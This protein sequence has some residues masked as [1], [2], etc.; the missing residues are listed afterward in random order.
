MF[1]LILYISCDGKTTDTADPL[2]IQ[3]TSDSTP[4]IEWDVAKENAPE[5]LFMS[6]WAFSDDDIWIVGGQVDSG[7]V[8]RGA[9]DQWEPLELPQDTP[10]LNW[11]NGT[12]NTDIWVGG[13]QGTLL[14]WNG[15]AWEDHSLDIEEAIWGI[16]AVSATDVIAVGGESKW[17]GSVAT[18]AH[19]DGS[20]WANID[21]PDELSDASNLFKVS[22]DGSQY[23]IVGA[24][25]ALI[26]G[27]GESFEA[28]P[29][30][31]TTD[32][33]TVH[34]NGERTQIV[35]GRGTGL[36]IDIDL[37][38]NL[39]S[40]VQAITGLNGV[41]IIDDSQSFVVGERGYGAFYSNGQFEEIEAITVDVLHATFSSPNGTIYAVGGNLFTSDPTFHGILLYITP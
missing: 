11:V 27:D 24:E 12:S 20:E 21:L 8:L 1:L 18:I 6:A 13:L 36:V 41:H 37:N 19:Y 10:L 30:G 23:W 34:H 26:T 31:I 29:S 16:Y 15:S 7:L 5:G 3:D 32:L 28:L 39:S 40:P 38:G 25:G 22:H 4:S 14:H 33:I 17:G 2:I 9:T 35:G